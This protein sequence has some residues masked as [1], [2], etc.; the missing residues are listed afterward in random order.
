MWKHSVRFL[1]VSVI[2]GALISSHSSGRDREPNVK[3][4]TKKPS[5]R[6]FRSITNLWIDGEPAGDTHMVTGNDI[7]IRVETEKEFGGEIAAAKVWIEIY[8]GSTPMPADV[9]NG[10]PNATFQTEVNGKRYWARNS[11]TATSST[12]PGTEYTIVVWAY[13]RKP[14]TGGTNVET[15][16]QRTQHTFKAVTLNP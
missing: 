4:N 2:V 7:D 14:A 15:L 9:P 8:D 12:S 13:F 1:T 16:Y 5:F 10:E 11:V 3:P 6:A